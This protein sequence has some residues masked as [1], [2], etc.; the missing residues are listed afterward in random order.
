MTDTDVMK[1]LWFVMET[2]LKFKKVML[3]KGLTRA[4]TKCPRCG[5]ENALQGA[6]AGRKNHLRMS[7]NTP[8]CEMS[9]M[10]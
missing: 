2:G 5:V 7:C 1:N 8:K 6:L 3:A 9:M 10:E 4:Q